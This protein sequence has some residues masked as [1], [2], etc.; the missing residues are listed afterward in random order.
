MRGALHDPPSVIELPEAN[1]RTIMLVFGIEGCAD[2][3]CRNPMPGELDVGARSLLA[4]AAHGYQFPSRGWY[5]DGRLTGLIVV[6][7]QADRVDPG[8]R[9]GNVPA[10][11][12]FEVGRTFG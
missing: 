3:I 10:R 6:H 4:D 8:G 7:Q 9:K 5:D 1:K 11:R 12:R 2:F